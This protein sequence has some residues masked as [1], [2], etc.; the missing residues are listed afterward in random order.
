M[1]SKASVEK[2]LTIPFGSSNGR[3]REFAGRSA[4]LMQGLANPVDG[5]L[6]RGRVAYDASL[7]DVFPARFKLRLNQ[8]YD[9]DH[10][11]QGDSPALPHRG[12]HCREHQRGRNERNVHGY[13]TNSRGK[14]ARLEVSGVGAL[15]QGDP[16]VPAQA[17]GNLPIPGIDSY[18]AGRAMLQHAVGKTAG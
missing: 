13:K 5:E 4:K 17:F 1:G 8:H 9:L 14:I 6:V 10:S 7:A 15:Q 18:D 2:K 12:D 3:I 11:L 16:W